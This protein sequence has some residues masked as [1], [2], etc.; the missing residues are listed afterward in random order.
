MGAFCT[1]L[2]STVEVPIAVPCVVSRLDPD[3]AYL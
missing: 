3:D 2:I 1:S